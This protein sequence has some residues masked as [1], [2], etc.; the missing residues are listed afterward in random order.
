[1]SDEQG[2][3]SVVF[4]VDRGKAAIFQGTEEAVYRW[5]ARVD[6]HSIWE[7]WNHEGGGYE[8][9][10]RFLERLEEKYKPKP[11]L[12]KEDVQR[13][14]DA[15]VREV[16][17]TVGKEAEDRS[18]GLLAYETREIMRPA[19]AAFQTLMESI[20]DKLAENDREKGAGG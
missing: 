10:W 2:Q 7:V 4:K 18:S 5:L 6:Q 11:Q 3:F 16:L 1:M 19:F 8:P 13:I 15:R 9:A 14:V 20:T 12:T 17:E